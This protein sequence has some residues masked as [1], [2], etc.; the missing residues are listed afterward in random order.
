MKDLKKEAEQLGIEVHHRWNEETIQGKINEKLAEA[1][2]EQ[3]MQAS[4][5]SSV[6]APVAAN[7][8]EAEPTPI[9]QKVRPVSRSQFA[10]ASFQERKKRAAALVRVRVVCMN[11]IKREWNGEIISTGSAKMGS[12]KKYI[13][14]GVEW[15][16]PRMMLNVLKEKKCSTFHNVPNGNGGMKREARQIAEYAI[17]ELPPLTQDE[18]KDLA[19]RQA[20]SEGGNFS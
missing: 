7:T 12:M 19:Q 4:S 5:E 3:A 1:Y 16:I 13:P 6:E 9:M 10:S 2:R 17:E 14:Y 18:L 8:V 20:M 11:P 15:H